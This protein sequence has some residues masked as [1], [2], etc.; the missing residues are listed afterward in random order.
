MTVLSGTPYP[1]AFSLHIHVHCTQEILRITGNIVEYFQKDT[2][3]YKLALY[4][5]NNHNNQTKQ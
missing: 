4:L 5:H 3:F 2:G 1:A